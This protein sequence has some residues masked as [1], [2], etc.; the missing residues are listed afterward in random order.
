MINPT[1][2]CVRSRSEGRNLL[3]C[4]LL[5]GHWHNDAAIDITLHL[6]PRPLLR[7]A[8]Q[9]SVLRGCGLLEMAL[10]HLG[11]QVICLFQQ[12]ICLQGYERMILCGFYPILTLPT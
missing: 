7:A 8:V 5:P 10:G 3:T 1:K 4:C 2:V 6:E 12:V 11:Q 9:V